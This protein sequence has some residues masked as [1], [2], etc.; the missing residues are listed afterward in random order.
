FVTL[1]AQH[2]Q[3][4]GIQHQA[5]FFGHV[6]LIGDLLHQ[7]VP[8]L[9]GHVVTH[10]ILVLELGPGHRFG[11][12]AEDDVGAAAGHVGGDGDRFVAAGLGDDVGL[13]VG[14]F[15]FGIEDVV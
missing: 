5:A 10:A 11:V 7:L 4:A 8:H 1:G 12:A 13:A 15:G 6:F 14:V 3:A 9:A 2:V